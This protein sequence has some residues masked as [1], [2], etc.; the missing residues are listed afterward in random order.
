MIFR[1]AAASGEGTLG[2]EFSVKFHQGK[3]MNYSSVLC[4]KQKADVY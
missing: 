2:L 1:S 3:M 4:R